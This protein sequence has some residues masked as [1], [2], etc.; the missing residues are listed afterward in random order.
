VRAAISQ[1]AAATG[2]NLR[3]QLKNLMSGQAGMSSVSNEYDEQGRVKQKTERFFNQVNTIDTTYNEHGDKVV[4]ITRSTEIGSEKEQSASRPG[5]PSYSE[6]RYSY[7]YD[8]HCNWTEE[9]VSYRHSAEG[10][11]ES[12]SARRRTLT[13]Y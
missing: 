2:E 7:Q 1:Q 8:D 3:E 4:E 6:V 10:A 12:S 5:L 13:Y 9:V 11:F